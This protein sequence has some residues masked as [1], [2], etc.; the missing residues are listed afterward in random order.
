MSSSFL[1]PSHFG[2]PF[3]TTLPTTRY[4]AKGRQLNF[5][6]SEVQRL[7]RL[8]F[9][10]ASKSRSNSPVQGLVSP[11]ASPVPSSA[12][13]IYTTPRS[14][15]ARRVPAVAYAPPT[16]KVASTFKPGHRRKGSSLSAIAEED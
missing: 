1:L 15:T 6:E 12:S 7:E 10:N 14:N 3:I 5:T 11:S 9:V 16:S 4:D 8:A 2:S 13:V